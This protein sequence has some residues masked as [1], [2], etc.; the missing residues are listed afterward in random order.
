[1]VDLAL[2]RPATSVELLLDLGA[3]HGVPREGLLVG[4]DLRADTLTHLDAEVTAAQELAVARALVAALG[5]PPC[6][7]LEA[8]A[9]YHLTTYGIWGFALA[10]SPTLRA[11]I[12]VGSRYLGLTYALTDVDVV[13]DPPYARV[14]LGSGDLPADVRRFLVVRDAAALRTLQRELF[15]AAVPLES[16]RLR[17]IA[18]SDTDRAR[19]EA[20]F[21]TSVTFGAGAD[22]VVLPAA[23]LDTPRPRAD[24]RTAAAA[25]A[26]CEQLLAERRQRVGTAGEVRGRLLRDPSRPPT[27]AEVAAERHVTERTL[28]RQLAAEGVRYRQLVDEVR[29]ALAHELL[30]VAGLSVEQTA[31]RLGFADPASLVHAF[32]RWTGTTPGAYREARRPGAAP[33][34]TADPVS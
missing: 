17:S 20:A 31:S 1:M 26:Q 13:V 34:E 16:V 8:G 22:E 19:Y 12:D 30:V 5:D 11:A 3:E 21:G 6:L 28:R 4:T 29:E 14:R 15:G 33:P 27:M 32:R 9:R 7:G 23:S 2:R 25:V 24:A 18:P 10:S